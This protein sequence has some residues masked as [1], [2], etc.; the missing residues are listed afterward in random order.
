VGRVEAGSF[1]EGGKKGKE[2]S[3]PSSS[4]LGPST[5]TAEGVSKKKEKKKISKGKSKEKEEEVDKEDELTSALER[6]NLAAEDGR[7]FSLSPGTR[8][9]L[10]RFTQIFKDI[11]TGVPTAYSDLTD[12]LNSSSSQLEETFTNLPGFMQRLIKTLPTKL[13]RNLSPELLRS[14]A[15]APV[16]EFTMPGLKEIV[17]KPGLLMGLLK[18]VVNVLKTRFPMLLGANAA[19]GM[20]LFVV[21]LIL[22]YCH[23]R[24][25]EVRLDEEEKMRAADVAKREAEIVAGSTGVEGDLQGGCQL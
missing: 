7:A 5:T 25:K 18:G 19:L 13:S 21:L 24:G 22:W 17:Q 20:A 12:L 16:A 3:S 4:S 23:K 14:A 15:A 9:L 11:L 2:N 8:A 1:A 10:T 6:L